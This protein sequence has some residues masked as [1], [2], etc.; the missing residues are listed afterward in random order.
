MTKLVIDALEMIDID[1][2]QGQGAAVALACGD[3]LARQFGHG[4]SIEHAGQR[5]QRGQP[6]QVLVQAFAAHEQEARSRDHRQQRGVG[7]HDALHGRRGDQAER[8]D[9]RSLE[10]SRQHDEAADQEHDRDQVFRSGDH[11]DPVVDGLDDKRAHQRQQQRHQADAPVRAWPHIGQ[12]EF[13]DERGGDNRDQQRQPCRLAV[14]DVQGQHQM[15]ERDAQQGVGDDDR[16]PVGYLPAKREQHVGKW[17]DEQS[18]HPQA[19]RILQ[20][21]RISGDRESERKTNDHGHGCGQLH[22]GGNVEIHGAQRVG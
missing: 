17:L 4:A 8:A 18:A 3:C 15:H 5:I 7:E 9:V 20:E 14:V 10:H 1:D 21:A 22:C 16:K 6:G 2:Q 19:H 11:L 13:A 12:Q